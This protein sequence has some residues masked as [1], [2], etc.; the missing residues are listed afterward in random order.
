MQQTKLTPEEEYDL[1]LEAIG[2]GNRARMILYNHCRKLWKRLVHNCAKVS[3]TEDDFEQEA[4][5]H[6]CAKLPCWDKNRSKLTTFMFL[7]ISR[8]IFNLIKSEEK[9]KTVELSTEEKT[10]RLYKSAGANSELSR[11][12]NTEKYVLAEVLSNLHPHSHKVIRHFF[13]GPHKSEDSI[14][15]IMNKCG[16]S[17]FQVERA[18]RALRSVLEH[19]LEGMS[20]Y[21]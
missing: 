10:D 9:Y 3:M 12:Q 8:H 18:R 7:T 13:F 19:R 15:T 20:A 5:L 21:A 4:F 16:A 14:H 17:Q 6:F 11:E 1:W 2:G